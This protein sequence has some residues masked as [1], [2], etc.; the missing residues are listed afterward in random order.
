MAT[1]PMARS[2]RL[3]MALVG[4][5]VGIISGVVIGVFAFVAGKL[6]KPTHSA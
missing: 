2:P 5:V 4:P 1:S 3:I 6:I